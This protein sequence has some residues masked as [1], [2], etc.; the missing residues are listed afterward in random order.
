[1]VFCVKKE[2]LRHAKLPFIQYYCIPALKR[3]IA[4]LYLS[5]LFFNLY[6]YQ[7]L[8]DHWQREEETALENEIHADLQEENLISIKVPAALPPYSDNLEQFEWISGE[9]NVEGTI[10]K[11]V[12]RRIFKDSV[13]FLCVPNIAKMRLENAR[14]DFFR[15]CND[16]QT[17]SKQDKNHTTSPVKP[18]TFDYCSEIIQY[19]ISPA[20]DNLQVFVTIY[21]ERQPVK[22]QYG[23]DHPPESGDVLKCMKA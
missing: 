1:M 14:E 18:I 23:I 4:I 5:I 13:E 16:L 6:G 10:Y 3:L 7:L 21:N 15:L 11:Y 8:I 19:Q 22:K 20:N 2:P 17:A 9:V 12:K